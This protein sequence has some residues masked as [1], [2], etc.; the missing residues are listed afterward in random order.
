MI[1]RY[2]ITQ[3]G[4]VLAE[5][6]NL[7]T[8]AGKKALL[9]YAARY[10]RQ[11]IGSLA[12]G[13]GSTA[14]NVADIALAFEVQRSALSGTSVDYV[15]SAVVYKATLPSNL[16]MTIYEVGAFSLE[17]ETE[18]YGSQLIQSFDE[19]NDAW[20]AGTF[21]ATNSRLGKALQITAAI[22]AST[23]SSL[24][25]LYIDL[26]G[27][28][29]S[30]KFI[31]ATRANNGSVSSAE[32]RFVT[33]AGNYYRLDLVS[34]ASGT[35]A[36]TSFNK[37]AAVKIGSPDWANITQIDIVV[38]STGGGSASM[39]FDAIR[40]EDVDSNNEEDVLV[41]RAVLGAPVVKESGLPLEIEYA[42]TF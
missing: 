31:T 35:Y 34:P 17:A 42:V 29:G 14:A 6:E 28:S 9:E 11:L 5:Q 13:V 39:D 36:I 4:K 8:T 32:I 27:Y 26:S 10:S 24:T 7:I 20:S 33:S 41:S 30:D 18:S 25:N 22:G 19:N 12:V 37:S 21:V 1:G 16:A 3:G 23:T 2:R 15:N 38:N 40:I